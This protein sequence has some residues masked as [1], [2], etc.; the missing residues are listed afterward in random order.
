[1]TRG[2]YTLSN[3]LCLCSHLSQQVQVSDPKLKRFLQGL[4]KVTEPS[5]PHSTSPGLLIHSLLFC[6]KDFRVYILS[7]SIYIRK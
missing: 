3:T 1:M 2:R 6:R 7:L 5:P 4:F